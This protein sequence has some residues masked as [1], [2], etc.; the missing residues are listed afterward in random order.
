[1]FS[2]NKLNG[3]AVV[4]TWDSEFNGGFKDGKKDG[5][6]KLVDHGEGVQY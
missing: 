2:N 3:E 4:I 5:Y 1:V 6:G